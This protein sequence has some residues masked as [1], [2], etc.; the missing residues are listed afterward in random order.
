MPQQVPFP[1]LGS[2]SKA[3]PEKAFELLRR[4]QASHFTVYGKAPGHKNF[5]PTAPSRGLYNC[6][7]IYQE[8]YPD[9]DTAQHVADGLTQA[10]PGWSFQV[11]TI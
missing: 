3:N 11:R 6:G 9:Q 10:N 8:R 2:G 4:F 1:G 7:L 5:H